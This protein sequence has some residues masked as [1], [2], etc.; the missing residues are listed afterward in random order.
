MNFGNLFSDTAIDAE[1]RSITAWTRIQR[2]PTSIQIKRDR[3][4]V[5]DAQTVRI[6][7]PSSGHLSGESGVSASSGMA[8]VF[9]IKDH[10]IQDDTDIEVGDRFV[11]SGNQYLVMFVAEYPGEIQ[12]TCEVQR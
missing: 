8:I 9:G 6:E 10:A 2:N 7:F 12:A 1:E 11:V 5:M 3:D 4:S